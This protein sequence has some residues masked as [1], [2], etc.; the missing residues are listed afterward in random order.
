MKLFENE[1]TKKR[2]E[3]FDNIYR[4]SSTLISEHVVKKDIFLLSKAIVDELREV[5]NLLLVTVLQGGMMTSSLIQQHLS[6][7]IPFEIGYIHT[8]TYKENVSTGNVKIISHS[9]PYSMKEKTV[10]LID[11]IFDKGL[12]LS[13]IHSQIKNFWKAKEVY[14]AVLLNKDIKKETD[15]RPNFIGRT[16]EDVFVFGMGM[17]VDGLWRGLPEIRKMN[18]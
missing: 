16:I 8:S 3:I 17:D 10:L 14:S 4:N 11:D 7:V 6:K 9:L 18:S 12:T 13:F 15:Y 1:A 2:V 5:E